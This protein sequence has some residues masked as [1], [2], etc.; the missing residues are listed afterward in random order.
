MDI[1]ELERKSWDLRQDVL[2][3]I[4][5]GG[6]GHIGGDMSLMNALLVLYKN[7]L[8]I[9]PE[10]VE[11]PDRDR[12][13]LS[14]GH[15]AIAYAPV[16]VDFGYMPEEELHIFNLTG[17]KIG[18]H[19]DCN[20]VRGVDVSTGSLGHG[21]SL[22]VG[23]AL[24][25]QQ[26]K[27]DY[28]VYC[29]TGDG[30]LNEGSN[31]EGAM[32]AAQ[33]KLSNIV[34]LVDNNKLMIDGAVKDEMNIEPVDEKFKAFGFDVLRVDGHNMKELNGAIEAAI[35]NHQNGGTKPT[36]IIMDTIKGEGIDFIA[37]DYTWHYGS[38]SDEMFEKA[39]ASL[40]EYYQ[41]RVARAEKE[42]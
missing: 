37:G 2:D 3:I 39:H 24:A 30:E 16:L 1:K 42:G 26:N 23:M 18:M 14:K 15:A 38:F 33:F 31:W 9:T 41:K 8:N 4:M 27:K 12:F 19:L 10:T 35:K 28:M 22:A 17:A 32:S 29:M 34:V 13:V 11:D 20:K 5:A 40:D 21:L 36:A 7:H 25:G 6:G